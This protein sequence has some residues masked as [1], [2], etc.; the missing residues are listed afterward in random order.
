MCKGDSCPGPRR[1]LEKTQILRSEAGGGVTGG[2]ARPRG[3]HILTIGR[4]QPN[5]CLLTPRRYGTVLNF[6]SASISSGIFGRSTP[7]TTVGVK[8]WLCGESR[9]TSVL[10]LSRP[11]S[12]PPFGREHEASTADPCGSGHRTQGPNRGAECVTRG[13][14]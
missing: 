3:S 2:E 11:L 1:D 9:T 12:R 5:S 6:F 4:S 14:N 7:S 8:T 13:Q 10:P